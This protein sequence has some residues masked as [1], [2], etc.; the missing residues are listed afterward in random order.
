MS[1]RQ[2]AYHKLCSDC[3]SVFKGYNRRQRCDACRSSHNKKRRAEAEQK[4]SAW[5]ETKA[6]IRTG[7]LVRQPCEVCGEVEVHAHHEDYSRPADVR[8]LCSKCHSWWHHRV[9]DVISIDQWIAE[10]RKRSVEIRVNRVANLIRLEL[11]RAGAGV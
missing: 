6:L 8:W 7:V 1:K 2:D 3:G 9:T 4:F 11:F 10:E 5:R